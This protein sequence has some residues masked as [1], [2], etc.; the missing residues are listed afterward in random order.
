MFKTLALAAAAAVTATVSGA[1]TLIYTNDFAGANGNGFVYNGGGAGTYVFTGG[2]KQGTTIGLINGITFDETYSRVKVENEKLLFSGLNG[3]GAALMDMGQTF[4]SYG[5]T[6]GGYRV[7]FDVT[8]S[9]NLDH[10][11]A[12]HAWWAHD[13]SNYAGPGGATTINGGDANTVVWRGTEAAKTIDLLVPITNPHYTLDLAIGGKIL[14][15]GQEASIDNIAIYTMDPTEFQAEAA[16]RAAPAV[17]P[18]PLPSSSLLLLG[19]LGGLALLRR[20]R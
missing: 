6:I 5:K 4:T 19:G 1:A 12:I 7:T 8:S 13:F 2:I 17:A 9:G 16:A 14:G 18:V 11:D 20:R 10:D 3:I 15:D